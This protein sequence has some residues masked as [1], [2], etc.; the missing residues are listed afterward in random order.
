MTAQEAYKKALLAYAEPFPL[1]SDV[2]SKEL[3]D[4]I[5]TDPEYCCYY[6]KN[7]IGD[8]WE[9][10]EDIIMKGGLLSHR[11]GGE[12]THVESEPVPVHPVHYMVWYAKFVV[13]G[14]LPNKMHNKMLLLAM[15]NPD[16]LSLRSYFEFIK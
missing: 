4:I 14:K 12:T 15:E 10:A 5:L 6:A 13:S 8:R 1:L 7:I 9:E 11:K 2:R 16:N 3:E